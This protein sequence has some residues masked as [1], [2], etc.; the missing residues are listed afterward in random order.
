MGDNRGD[1]RD[2]RAFGAVALDDVV[3]RA[4][5]LVWPPRDFAT[6]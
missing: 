5:L 1:S 4:F 3:G 2:S 6:L